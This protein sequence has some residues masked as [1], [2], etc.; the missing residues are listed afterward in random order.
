[1]LCVDL[2][3]LDRNV[4]LMADEIS[5]SG[6]QWRPHV[7]SHCQP[8]LMQRMVDAGA[9]GVTCASVAE[10]EV[11]A[12]AGAPSILIAHIVVNPDQLERLPAINQQTE[13][14]LTVDH[15]AQAELLVRLAANC[16]QNFK[17]LVDVNVGMNRTG[18]RPGY[19]ALRL[20]EAIDKQSGVEVVGIM[21]YEGHL[22]LIDDPDEKR[23]KIMDAMGV[24]QHTQT[25]IQQKGICCD[26]VSAGGTGSYQITKDHEAVTELQ[27]G[28]G[29]FGDLFYTKRCG[30]KGV[31][32][33]LFVTADV[34]SRPSL[35]QAVLNCGR[36]MLNI[37]ICKPEITGYPGAT[38]ERF[39]AEHC[40]VSLKGAA[41]DLKIGDSV[42]ML[43]GY[44]DLT[45]LMHRQ[46][47]VFRG[48][49]KIDS[50]PIVRNC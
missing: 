34:V 44:S 47:A 3:I 17:V 46:I 18:I 29:I 36:K 28:G 35:E 11:M 22:L 7:K 8:K 26:I 4:K 2:D 48:E 9:S 39:S 12:A 13:L 37:E 20:A 16:S 1:M 24:L 25:L 41:R 14:L 45:L 10:A 50:W 30:T 42:K 21:G 6:K 38:A 19:D 15:F 43:I 33:A 5:S 27:A 40:V 23:T 31:E 49:Q 32:P